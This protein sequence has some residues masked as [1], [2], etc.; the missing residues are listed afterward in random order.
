MQGRQ[1][2]ASVMMLVTSAM[3]EP[4][5]ITRNGDARRRAYTCSMSAQD[6]TQTAARSAWSVVAWAMS[7][8]VRYGMGRLPVGALFKHK[9]SA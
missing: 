6:S 7:A 1:R 5:R 3:S 2:F 4:P 9:T 8:A